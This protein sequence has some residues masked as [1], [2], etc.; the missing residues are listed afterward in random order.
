MNR[1]VYFLL[2]LSLL[3][4]LFVSVEAVPAPRH[5]GTYKP[6]KGTSHKGTSHKG[7]SHQ[8]TSG[9]G[10]SANDIKAYLHAHNK[11]R[12]YH[13]AHPLKWNSTLAAAAQKEVN[14]CI[15][16]HSGGAF[17]PYGENLAAG[18]GNF[19]IEDGIRGWTNELRHYNPQ[20][21]MPSHF[22]QVVWKGS[23]QVGCAVQDCHGI[24]DPKYGV[25]KFYACEYWPQGNILGFFPYNVVVKKP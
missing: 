13:S 8:G 19:K 7:T 18:T 3:L 24:F 21:P 15:F 25:A 4:A 14:R 1:F 12:G 11:F 9:K 10:T 6:T 23:Q 2:S 20:N 22:T 16:K 17:G 5:R